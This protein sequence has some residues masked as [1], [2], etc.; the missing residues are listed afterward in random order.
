[1]KYLIHISICII[2]GTSL[3]CPA[4]LPANQ[5]NKSFDAPP[6]NVFGLYRLHNQAWERLPLQID[7]LDEDGLLVTDKTP[8]QLKGDA[9]AETDR[10]VFRVEKTGGKWDGKL[11]LPCGAEKFVELEHENGRYVYITQCAQEQPA[12]ASV[13]PARNYQGNRLV[14]TTMYRYK[15]F[16][17]NQLM[18]EN[19]YIKDP[20]KKEKYLAAK[21]SNLFLHIDPKPWFSMSFD[22]NDVR[23]ISRQ[24]FEGDVGFVSNIRF[25]LKLLFFKIDLKMD[26]SV[27]Y[28]GDSA[29][30]PMKIDVPVKSKKMLNPGSAVS[31]IWQ[32]GEAKFDLA[33]ST[34]P[35]ANAETALKGWQSNAKKGL[36]I[37]AGKEMCNYRLEGKV[38]QFPFFLDV[39]VP[40]NMVAE[41]F[42][43]QFI[44][45]VPAFKKK[46][47]WKLDDKEP[48]DTIGLYFDNS[49]LT[50]G[51]HKISQWIRVGGMSNASSCPQK[52]TPTLSHL[53]PGMITTSH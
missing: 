50:K 24:S 39:Y 11:K 9:I 13:P 10:F 36:E 30:I 29:L 49:G 18:Y 16:A 35:V 17:N 43:P 25:F 52:V 31:F 51:I 45:G 8:E 6:R 4:F 32:P 37:C 20:W 28:Y 14:N 41:G 33:Q 3:G 42:Y 23:S 5:I 7:P 15:Y 44:N 40:Q 26:T 12:I 21:Q 46:M 27:A 38:K 48:E 1:M 53:G 47:D 22:N 19:L 2:S 34:M